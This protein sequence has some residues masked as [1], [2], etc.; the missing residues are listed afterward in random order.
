[1]I[2]GREAHLSVVV[3]QFESLRDYIKSATESGEPIHAVEKQLWVG[4]RE[5]GR[6]LLDA[7]VKMQ[8]DGNEG[9][10]VELPTEKTVSRLP[11]LHKKRYVS[12]FGEIMIS[13]VVYGTRETQKIEFVP[14]D[15][16]LELPAEE[17]S[18]LL[19]DWSQS[20]CVQNSYRESRNAIEKIL[21]IGQSVRTLEQM[22]QRMATEVESF[23]ESQPAPPADEE[24]EFVV[25]TADGKGVPMRQ[26]SETPAARKARLKKG[27]KR[28]TKRMACAAGVY[29]IDPFVRTPDDILN[30]IMRKEKQKQRP[31]P[32]HK[33][34]RADLSID[35]DGYV[36][37]AKEIAYRWMDDEIKA[38][39]P[40]N[41][42]TILHLTDGEKKLKTTAENTF[43]REVISILDIYHVM[44]RLWNA[45]H[46]F[47]REG[48][49]ETETFVEQRLRMLLEGKVEFVIRGLRQMSTKRALKGSKM[50]T[51]AQVTGY[52]ENNIP[53]MKYDQYI[54]RGYPIGTGVVEGACRHLVKDRMEGAGMRWKTEGAQSMLSMRATHL[55]DEWDK[56]QDYRIR[57][58]TERLYPYKELADTSQ[59][60]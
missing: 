35:Y 57:E 58:Q 8:G 4:T 26:E 5:L 19:Q 22:N 6:L 52:F 23:R 34:L 54:S 27:E 43:S 9:E 39:D 12:V 14:L 44:E 51:I 1:M 45:A 42:K 32:R 41:Q 59:W 15:A 21:G 31:K 36:S 40:L 17:Q 46:C 11:N 33:R 10:Q 37:N 25:T 47:H 24:G 29:S 56:Y 28:Q 30:E 48:T 13:R 16:R 55:N 60:N 18:Y 38:R 49:D 3:N 53:R 2:R 7:F 20:F 50:K